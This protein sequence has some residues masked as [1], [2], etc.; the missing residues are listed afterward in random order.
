MAAEPQPHRSARGPAI[1]ALVAA[2]VAVIAFMV[3]R[4]DPAPTAA[5]PMPTASNASP[6]ATPPAATSGENTSGENG[7][8]G[9]SPNAADKESGDAS[10]DGSDAGSPTSEEPQNREDAVKALSKLAR[11][12]PGGPSPSGG[13]T[14]RS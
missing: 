13:S 12:T 8:L 14:H 1:I 2:V 6:T 11:R 3:S 10:F 4:E 9:V 7:T 5:R